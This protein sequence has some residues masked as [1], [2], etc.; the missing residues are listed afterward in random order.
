MTRELVWPVDARVRI[1]EF[2]VAFRLAAH[3]QN[4]AHLVDVETEAGRVDVD[5]QVYLT[6]L[7]RLRDQVT[8]ITRGVT[9]TTHHHDLEQVVA[10]AQCDVA[11]RE[12]V[13][14]NLGAVW[15]TI[16]MVIVTCEVLTYVNMQSC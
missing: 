1:A 3:V 5:R 15:T 4:V 10:H 14:R 2:V 16:S 7:T 8:A 11:V 13:E 9:V 6:V 12:V